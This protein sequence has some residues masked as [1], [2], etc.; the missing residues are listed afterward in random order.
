MEKFKIAGVFVCL[1]LLTLWAGCT[2]GRK[3]YQTEHWQIYG[4]YSE[5]DLNKWTLHLRNAGDLSALIENYRHYKGVAV[6][7]TRRYPGRCLEYHAVVSVNEW[8]FYRRRS[9]DKWV[10]TDCLRHSQ[11]PVTDPKE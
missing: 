10:Q 3:H 2:S 9:P 1:L 11:E 6:I 7:V 4:P 5:T 8:S